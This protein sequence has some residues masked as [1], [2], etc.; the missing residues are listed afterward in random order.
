MKIYDISQE[1]FSCEVYPGD[2]CPQKQSAC[3]MDE[4]DS[5]NLTNFSM[6]AHNGTHIDAPFHFLNDGR[7][8]ENIELQ[9]FIGMCYVAAFDGHLGTGD[10]EEIINKAK[11]AHGGAEKRILLRGNAV[12][13][14]ESAEVFASREI[15]LLGVESQSVG[16]SVSPAEVHKILLGR[17]VV[18]L[19]GIRLS[20]MAEG[21]YFLNCAPL[22]LG[23]C[24]GS[25]CRAVLIEDWD[26]L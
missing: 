20:E 15:Y 10:A 11:N 26:E 2:D 18:L 3:R 22:S 4:G 1:V 14:K 12:V 16:D 8:V 21:V 7:T 17:E 25:P 6:C 9:K 19:E 13:T 23:G 24:D 5:Y